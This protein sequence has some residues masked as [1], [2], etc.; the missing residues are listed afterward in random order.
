MDMH[1]HFYDIDTH[2]ISPCLRLGGGVRYSH[3]CCQLPEIGIM[4][5]EHKTA[6]SIR[7]V[8]A[9]MIWIP[10]SWGVFESVKEIFTNKWWYG[11]GVLMACLSP[12]IIYSIWVVFL[13]D[14]G[15]MFFLL[16]SLG[17]HGLIFAW[18][19]SSAVLAGNFDWLLIGEWN[20]VCLKIF[21]AIA[22][23][24]VTCVDLVWLLGG[25]TRRHR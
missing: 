10:L 3:G 1:D 19:L 18:T 11:L 24:T 15:N 7:V 2:W 23:P 4:Q 22:A 25:M 17:F 12:V 14:V 20:E 21:G 6:K 8:L 5:V 16:Y 13:K 9:C